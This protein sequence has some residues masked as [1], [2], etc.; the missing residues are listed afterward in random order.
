MTLKEAIKWHED[1]E[2]EYKVLA[3]EHEDFAMMA[4]HYQQL[5]GW[6]KE[7]ETLR[8]DVEMWSKDATS[9]QLSYN[10]L[11]VNYKK[12][13]QLLKSAV[14]DIHELLCD[15]K[16]LDGNGQSCNIC[17]YIEW[18]PCC[19]ECTIREDLRNWRYSDEVEKLLNYPTETCKEIT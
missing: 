12:A 13:K 3:K 6:L 7:V 16:N 9:L 10:E 18:C 1:K 15:K 5:A 11:L 2:A 19:K 4:V 17:S 8:K 14:E